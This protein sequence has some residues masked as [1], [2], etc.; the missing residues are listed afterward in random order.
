VRGLAYWANPVAAATPTGIV[1][2][3]TDDNTILGIDAD[4][5][6]QIWSQPTGSQCRAGPGISG[7]YV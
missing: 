7:G 6:V 4:S 5:G 1:A 3:V 2:A